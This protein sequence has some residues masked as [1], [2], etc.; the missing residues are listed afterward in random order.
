[1]G[2]ANFNQFQHKLSHFLESKQIIDSYSKRY[3]FGTDASFYRLVPKLILQLSNKA[4]VKQV[5]EL[6]NQ[7]E[8]PV[9]F[10][11]AGT[12][13]SGQAITDSVLILLTNDW[14]HAQIS[15]N[16]DKICLQPGIIGA[17]VNRLLAP[18][19]RKIG[20]DPASIDSCKIGGIA[21][22]NAS[23]MC[24]GVKQNSYHTVADMTIIFANGSELNTADPASC[25]QFIEQE[26][27]LIAQL[28][29]LLA[30]VRGDSD[31]AERI[32]H[33]FRL[34][35]TCGYGINS[36]LDFSDPIDVIKHLLIGSEGTLGFIADITYHTVEVHPHKLTGF[37]VFEQLNQ[38]CDLVSELAKLDVAAV[39]LLDYR[40]LKSVSDKPILSP[41]VP[42]LTSNSAALL[43][44]LQA[45]TEN[46]LKQLQQ[47]TLALLSS[48]NDSVSFQVSFSNDANISNNLWKIRK[49]TFPAVGAVRETG[50]TVIIEDVA[51]PIEKLAEGVK[52]LQVLFEKYHY[53]EAIIFGHALA[54]NLHFVFTQ[55]FDSET[56]KQRYS[57]FMEDVAQLVAV[58]YQGSLK[59][60][61]GTGR[62]MAPFV[63]LE[64]GNSAYQL[65]SAIKNTFDPKGILNPGVILNPD[66]NVHLQN[67][68]SLPAADDIID[69]CIE[70]GFCESV[71]PSTNFTFTPRQRITIWRRIK[72][73]SQLLKQRQLSS[74]EIQALNQE[75]TQLQEDYQF[76]AIDS[77]AATGLCGLKCPVGINT[78][79]FIKSLRADAFKQKPMQ[80]K[81]SQFAAKHLDSSLAIAKFGLSMVS[82]ANTLLP[83]SVVETTF[84]GLNKL[85]GERIP[86]YYDA[87][88]KGEKALP[89]T[90]QGFKESSK[91]KVI[92]IPS[93]AT[94]TFAQDKNASDKRPLADVV[95][96]ILVKA[97]FEVII[98][99]AVD[100]L[101]CGLPF[102]SKGD[103]QTAKSKTEQLVES[104]KPLAQQDDTPVILDASSCALH[105][106]QSEQNKHIRFFELSDFLAQ[107]VLPELSIT[108]QDEPVSLHVTC[109]T[110]RNQ[111]DNQLVAIAKA[112]A[113]E[114]II[115]S[116]IN[117]CGFAGDKG[118]VLPE[119]NENALKPLHAQVTG[120]IKQGF[121]NNRT[122]EI[123]LTKAT[124]VPYQSIVYLLDKVSSAQQ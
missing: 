83:T 92:Y 67:L 30:Q 95:M 70:C 65:M 44:E 12:S 33:K 97:G 56:E 28:T 61:H 4:Q 23:G 108:P 93:C 49:D 10:R 55:A 72:E 22:N 110:I 100:G 86:L 54:G 62:N 98:P 36:L 21:A 102:A 63:E 19:A 79:E 96:S 3:A 43:I 58:R 80:Q 90:Q 77:C 120:V 118:F 91:P 109:S 115:P 81:I 57:N 85:S 94:R 60:E 122:C 48:L 35:N 31:L 114:V 59:A 50:T 74:T 64:W 6:A 25:Q 46:D 11:A 103:N 53:N 124:D 105:V 34:K 106:I 8:V 121:S 5:L 26:H 82:H 52:E 51:F 99:S 20:P 37:Y 89:K 9:T 112:C 42:S 24:C 45:A 40:A 113:K 18:Y 41:C 123:G 16:G 104:I 15:N 14:Q 84:K 38:A 47:Q 39:E 117:C 107:Y 73:I 17:K 111:A 13:L 87:W 78:G 88:P 69:K 66:D 75:Q 7:Y 29:T 71:C 119:L 2:Q 27:V 116:D 1:M 101:C 76:L 32:R 68:K